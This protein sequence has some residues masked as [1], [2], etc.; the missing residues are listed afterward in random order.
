MKRFML[1]GV[2]CLGLMVMGCAST[3]SHGSHSHSH[4][5]KGESTYT[6]PAQKA[7]AVQLT[8]TSHKP[9]NKICPIMGGE[10]QSDGGS[11]AWN[12][13]TVG[14]CC[15]GC[16]EEWMELDESQKAQ[17]LMETTPVKFESPTYS[18]SAGST[19]R[20]RSN[21]SCH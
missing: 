21:K 18:A 19:L 14:F 4:A 20:G 3:K 10:V 11:T 17:K 8:Q 12:G 2:A 5:I 16:V 1:L 7:P 13:K 6:V 15:P 9:V